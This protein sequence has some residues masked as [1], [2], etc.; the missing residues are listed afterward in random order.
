MLR[1]AVLP[2]FFVCCPLLVTTAFFLI[3]V[4]HL[5]QMFILGFD[6]SLVSSHHWITKAVSR[7]AL[8]GVILF[9][10]NVDGT[11]QNVSSPVQLQELTGY[12]Q[13]LTNELLLIAVDQ[14][15]GQVCRLKERDGF[16]KTKSA[17]AL[18]ESSIEKT[19]RYAGNMAQTLSACGVN[20]NL[21]PVVD[22]RLNEENPIIARYGRSFGATVARVVDHCS[23]FIQA[24]HQCGIACCLKHFPGH[25]SARGDSHKGFVDI[26]EDWQEQELEPYQHIFARGFSDA[27][28][29]AH[30][31]HRLLEPTGYPATLSPVIMRRLLRKQLGF[32]GVIMT[33]DLQMKAIADHYGYREAVQRAVL[34]GVDM[35][36]VG[37]NLE[38]SGNVLEEGTQ[39]IYDLLETGQI[40]VEQIQQS[41]KRIGLLK[42]KILGSKP[43]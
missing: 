38:R 4:M 34:A 25:G 17:A 1:K 28:M 42:Q 12:L 2:V 36:I 9:D 16:P 24:H 37:N 41:I 26:T 40:K 27:V 7:Q 14:E 5:G 33:D 22:V 30:L 15:G 31:V 19:K 6:G 43:W 13:G 3:E 39:A 20:L 8:G 21:A 18:G 23:A 35:I 10:R 32:K 11:V 29:T